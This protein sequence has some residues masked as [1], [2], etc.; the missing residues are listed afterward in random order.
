MIYCEYYS[1]EHLLKRPVSMVMMWMTIVQV[2]DRAIL[3]TT[4]FYTFLLLV[5]MLHLFATYLEFTLESGN[6]LHVQKIQLGAKEMDCF[7]FF[8]AGRFFI[9]IF[10]DVECFPSCSKRFYDCI[11]FGNCF[12]NEANLLK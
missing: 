12:K 9:I 10:F 4:C 6:G 1:N 8:V 7:F 2:I 3:S 11:F 5:E